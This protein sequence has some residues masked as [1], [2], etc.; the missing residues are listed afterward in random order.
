MVPGGVVLL[1]VV[2]GVVA[3]VDAVGAEIDV[4]VDGV[5]GVA[6]AGGGGGF[7]VGGPEGDVVAAGDAEL[8]EPVVVE[9]DGGEDA[10]VG[11][12]VDDVEQGVAEEVVV[13]RELGF[14][15]G[16][17]DETADAEV[18]ALGDVGK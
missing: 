5:G 1:E 2:E 17:G 12:G 14:D 11:E 9:L 10:G 18:H 3:V 6:D 4:V 13:G 8:D 16:D 7:G 15:A